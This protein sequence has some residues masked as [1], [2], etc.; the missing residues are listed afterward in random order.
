MFV[1]ELNSP[2][3]MNKRNLF[4]DYSL[5][6]LLFSN[7][8]IIFFAIKEH[9]SLLNLMWIYWAQSVIIGLFNFIRIL[10]LKEFSTENFYSNGRP[11]EPTEGT[12]ISTAFF[13]L[14]HYGFFHLGYFLF[15]LAGPFQSN[16]SLPIAQL[17]KNFIAGV[18]GIDINF[19][20]FSVLVFFINHLFSFLYNRPRDTKKQ[21]IGTLMFYPYAR[22]IPMHLMI[23]FSGAGIGVFVALKTLADVIMH[24]VEHKLKRGEEQIAQN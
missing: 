15:L 10:L 13:F 21:N 11:V 22:I 7:L 20:L 23:G 9:Q 17:F 12:K 24:S 6:A 1:M 14:F 8:L 19:I 3:Q 2:I 18:G 16:Q 5:W 4:K